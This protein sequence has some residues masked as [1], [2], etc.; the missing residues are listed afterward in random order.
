MAKLQLNSR[1][2]SRQAIL[3]IPIALV[4]SLGWKDKEE[5]DVK[6]LSKINLEEIQNPDI[7]VVLIKK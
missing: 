7:K 1:G 2:N 6:L 4:D 5:I 3:T